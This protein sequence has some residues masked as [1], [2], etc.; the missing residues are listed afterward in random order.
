M[1]VKPANFFDDSRLF[2][3]TLRV[4]ARF[5]L[6]EIFFGRPGMG[7]AFIVPVSRY[8]ETSLITVDF[9]KFRFLA[10]CRADTPIFS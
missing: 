7:L 10:I 9:A 8:F 1:G 6:G 4:N 3:R 5:A 2:F